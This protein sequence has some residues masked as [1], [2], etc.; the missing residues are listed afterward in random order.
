LRTAFTFVKHVSFIDQEAVLEVIRASPDPKGLSEAIGEHWEY[1]PV[2]DEIAWEILKRDDGIRLLELC[3]A[4][5]I[6]ERWSSQRDDH[7]T[8]MLAYSIRRGHADCT[9][10]LLQQGFELN[11]AMFS[12]S[13][14]RTLLRNA[15]VQRLAQRHPHYAAAL[16]PTPEDFAAVADEAAGLDLIECACRCAEASQRTGMPEAFD[17]TACLTGLVR[18]WELCSDEAMAAVATRLISLGARVQEHHLAEL[19][20]RHTEHGLEVERTLQVCTGN[21]TGTFARVLTTFFSQF[22]QLQGQGEDG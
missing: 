16:A 17:P 15:E 14:R 12:R 13:L 9:D 7:L 8:R 22:R 1:C 10:L 4:R 21:E 6:Y 3:L 11:R 18:A 19:R 20:R 2:F 5:I